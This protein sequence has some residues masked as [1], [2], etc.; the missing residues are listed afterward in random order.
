MKKLVSL[1]IL[2]VLMP[3]LC[4]GEEKLN[5]QVK[6][7]HPGIAALSPAL[8]ELFSKEMVE[9]QSGMIDIIPL[10]I[11]GKLDDIAT[12]AHKMKSSYVL[13]KNLSQSQMHELH[14]KLPGS[15]IELDQHFH[16]LAGMLEHVAKMEKIE[17]V[18]FYISEMGETC[19]RCHSEYATQRFPAFAPKK[20]DEQSH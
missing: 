12:I 6:E 7:V 3:V 2:T 20:Q 19:V 16:Y 9:L 18:G 8:R 15:F 14:S 13:K 1:A 10:Y 5:H 4:Y 11:S 17:L